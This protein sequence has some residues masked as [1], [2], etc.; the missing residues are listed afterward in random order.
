VP[1]SHVIVG[2]GNPGGE[3]EETRHNAGFM[4]VDRLARRIGCEVHGKQYGA[5][6]GRGR[7]GDQELLLVEPQSYMNLSG[8]PVRKAVSD[9]GLEDLRKL[10]VVHDEL[11]LP[12]GRLKLVFDRG[13]GG[14][15]GVASIISSLGTK[16]FTRV[17]V[18][19]D[20]PTRSQTVDWVLTKFSK[21]EW[22]VMDATIDRA[23]AAIE[24]LVTKGFDAAGNEFNRDEEAK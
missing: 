9:Q 2:L 22:Q 5:R 7:L 15:K 14:N 21:S 1:A 17:R 6:V 8:D 20:K 24:S 11:D 12:V 18:G 13:A 19:I 23:V 3:Y 4:V 10:I 16:A